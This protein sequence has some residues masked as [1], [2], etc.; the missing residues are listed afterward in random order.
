[1]SI[2][3]NSPRGTPYVEL[4]PVKNNA[5]ADSS[6]TN[7]VKA[8]IIGSNGQALIDQNYPVNLQVT[9]GSLSPLKPRQKLPRRT[10]D[11]CELK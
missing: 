7:S 9:S 2:A 8:R 11:P 1:M 3:N 5:P 10:Q 6:S 4:T